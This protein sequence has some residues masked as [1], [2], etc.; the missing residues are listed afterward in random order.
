MPICDNNPEESLT[1]CGYSLFSHYS[2]DSNKS[3]HYFYISEDCM[4]KFCASLR[5]HAT[6]IVNCE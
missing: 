4:K 3:T 1:V 2:F 6:E 5:K